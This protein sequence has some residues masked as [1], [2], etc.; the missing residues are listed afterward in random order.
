MSTKAK[1][2]VL[3]GG[4][5][6]RFNQGTKVHVHKGLALLK[7]KPLLFHVLKQ[8]RSTCESLMIVV[9][10]NSVKRELEQVFN[11]WGMVDKNQSFEIIIDEPLSMKGPLR[12][13]LTGLN[14]ISTNDLVITSACDTLVPS[15][16]LE[17]FLHTLT[18]QHVD[19]VMLQNS[20]KK[21]EPTV[22][23]MKMSADFQKKLQVL[24]EH[25]Q[26]RLADV[27]RLASTIAIVTLLSDAI[28]VNVNTRED[29][30]D[31]QQ[32]HD[33]NQTFDERLLR[34][35]IVENKASLYFQ[36]FIA[37]LMEKNFPE[38]RHQ[39]NEEFSVLRR[40]GLESI[41]RHVEKDLQKLDFWHKISRRA[42]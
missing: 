36:A 13:L 26:G 25:S 16:V 23:G 30:Q 15:T 37:A 38:A 12:G 5:S 2:I 28:L 9:N 29:L 4:Q 33:L 19:V 41:A 17:T 32:R 8:L 24:N 3:A 1:G 34:L 18:T 42:T 20:R 22:L 40:D 14:R 35:E 7:G 10:D 6:R 11:Q 27:V 39:L 31:L 21:L